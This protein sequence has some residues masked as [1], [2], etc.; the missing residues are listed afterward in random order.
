VLVFVVDFRHESSTFYEGRR[1]ERVAVLLGR[2]G[3]RDLNL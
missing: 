3:V 2:T 1:T